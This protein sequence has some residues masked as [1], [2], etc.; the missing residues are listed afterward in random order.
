[1]LTQ[2]EIDSLTDYLCRLFNTSELTVLQHPEDDEQ[3]L[4][5]MG[6]QFFARIE[7]DED[8]GELSYSFSKEVPDQ[9][10]DEMVVHFQT[11]FNSQT[12]E[13]R[14]RANKADS[15]EVYKSD[16]FLGVIYDDDSNAEGTQIFNMAILDIDLMPDE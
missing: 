3:A 10:Y 5:A 6:Q 9:P 8:E 12:V 13:V 4:V 7:R 14:K 15:V 2:S 1:M 11:I 16:E